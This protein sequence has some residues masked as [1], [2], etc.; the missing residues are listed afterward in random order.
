MKTPKQTEFYELYA[1][2][3]FE[4]KKNCKSEDKLVLAVMNLKKHSD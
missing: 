3:K 2:H 4:A 1:I